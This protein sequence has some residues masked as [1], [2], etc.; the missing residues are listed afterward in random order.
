[1][2]RIN[3]MSVDVEDYFQVSAFEGVVPRAQWEAQPARVVR[4]TEA[5]LDLFAEHGVQAT[6][7]TLGWVASRWPA[8]VRRIV[9]EGHEL[10]SHGWDHTRATEQAPEAFFQD[11]DRTRKLLEDVGGVAVTGYRAASYSIDRRN[12]WAFAQLARAG[13]RYSS[14]V[15][16][17]RHDLYGVP[18]A[19]LTPFRPDDSG[20]LE[21]PVSV[22]EVAGRRLPAGGGGFFRLYPYAFSRWAIRRVNAAGRTLVFYFHPWE[23][24]PRQPRLRQ[25]P[26]KSRFRHYLNLERM[27]PRLRRLL[28][29]FRWGRMDHL[30]LS[31]PV[32]EE[33]KP[34]E[35]ALS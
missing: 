5:V 31:Q 29:D 16:P 21:I 10:A 23:I 25:A 34:M 14:S 18:E 24:D 13:Y 9:A 7:F 20:I 28:R 11:V 22:V 2:T 35:R 6:F 4:N 15:Y 17:V 3:A 27:R 8:L 26:W 32:T 19:P 30:F 1:M 33:F 12:W